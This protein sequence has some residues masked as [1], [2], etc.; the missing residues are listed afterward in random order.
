[1]QYVKSLIPLLFLLPFTMLLVSCDDNDVTGVDDPSEVPS[2]PNFNQMQMETGIFNPG[3]VAKE[4]GHEPGILSALSTINEGYPDM[5][6]DQETNPYQLASFLVTMLETGHFIHNTYATFFTMNVIPGTV[7]VSGNEFLWDFSAVDPEFGGT[8]DITA[9]AAV[10]G[11]QV[12]WT[13]IA[14]ADGEEGGFEEQQVIDGISAFDGSSGE[15]SISFDVQE[16]GFTFGSTA[17]WD[18]EDG[19]LTALDLSTSISEDETGFYQHTEGVYALDGTSASISNG[20]LQSPEYE[21]EGY[22]GE[23][24]ITQP[25][26]VSWDTESGNGTVSIDGQTMC[27][28][29]DQMAVDC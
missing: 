27:W 16:D 14:G 1:M 18:S 7:E 26:T 5:G 2:L 6:M 21:D 9:T 11:E 29:E 10:E 13:V 22:F 12:L 17:I 19:Q 24:D 8:I 25:F 28:D 20:R 4:A 3:A 23:I 15:W